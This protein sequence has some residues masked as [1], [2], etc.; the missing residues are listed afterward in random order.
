MDMVFRD[1]VHRLRRIGRE[2]LARNH[3]AG[4]RCRRTRSVRDGQMKPALFDYHA[5]QTLDDAV[6]LLA[7]I[8]G[9]MILAG[10]QSLVPGMN[11]RLANPAAL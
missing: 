9:A 2:T 5:P 11:M 10:G 8:D 4:R 3:T 7:D 6:A 1:R